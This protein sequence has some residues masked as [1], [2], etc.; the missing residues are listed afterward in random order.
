[1][2]SVDVRWETS[3]KENAKEAQR[4][5][6]AVYSEMDA[7][8]MKSHRH[9]KSRAEITSRTFDRS[10]NKGKRAK[11]QI[12]RIATQEMRTHFTQK[13]IKKLPKCKC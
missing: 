7:C 6:A 2:H 1:M 9:G 4:C 12:S 3:V 10:F 5:S 8:A 11:L 13:W